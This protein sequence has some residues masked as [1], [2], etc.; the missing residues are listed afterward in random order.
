MSREPFF[1]RCFIEMWIISKPYSEVELEFFFL[2]GILAEG[3]NVSLTVAKLVQ[4]L[5]DSTSKLEDV[6]S[7]V[8][9]G[10]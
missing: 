7:I 8:Q 9:I 2:E 1:L 6:R 5:A 3:E 4:T 10:I